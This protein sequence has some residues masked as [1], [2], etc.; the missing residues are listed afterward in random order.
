VRLI[1]DA[2]N[3]VQFARTHDDS[4]VFEAMRWPQIMHANVLQVVPEALRDELDHHLNEVRAGRR[5]DAWVF[6]SMLRAGEMRLLSAVPVRNH[7]G[8]VAI[9]VFWIAAEVDIKEGVTGVEDT[10]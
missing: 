3:L 5:P 8:W 1:V 6:P 7:E 9:T 10:G 2:E 4:R